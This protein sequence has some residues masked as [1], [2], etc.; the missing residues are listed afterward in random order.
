MAI[1]KQQYLNAHPDP[2]RQDQSHTETKY[3]IV[4][5]PNLTATS[6]YVVEIQPNHVQEMYLN[7]KL[8]AQ[9]AT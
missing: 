4:A 5:S 1:K 2:D 8:V 6:M 7:E 3:P 9:T